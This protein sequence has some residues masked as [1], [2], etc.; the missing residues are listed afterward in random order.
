MFFQKKKEM[1]TEGYRNN[2]KA[3]KQE[4]ERL[5]LQSTEKS[6]RQEVRKEK[7]NNSPAGALFGFGS[8]IVSNLQSRSKTS[9]GRK[10]NLTSNNIFTQ[11]SKPEDNIYTKT[12]SFGNSSNYYTSGFR[13]PMVGPSTQRPKQ[14]SKGKSITLNFR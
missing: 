13:N 6:L 5:N 7:F 4:K 1:T 9:G 10:V 3:L 8:K 11:K 2:I 12:N 14:K